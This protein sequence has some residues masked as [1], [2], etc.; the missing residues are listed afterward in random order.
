MKTP[1]VSVSKVQAV[2]GDVCRR[3]RYSQYHQFHQTAQNCVQGSFDP[4][5]TQNPWVC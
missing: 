1:E 5:P 2:R 3:D 4:K